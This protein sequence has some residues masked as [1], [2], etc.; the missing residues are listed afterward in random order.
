MGK[1]NIDPTAFA[2]KSNLAEEPVH[3]VDEPEVLELNPV[4]EKEHEN[5]DFDN[6]LASLFPGKERK[7]IQKINKSFYLEQHLVQRLEEI[8]KANDCSSSSVLNDILK[9]IL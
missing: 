9:Q 8:G 6:F 5:K 4:Q 7:K 2:Y 3:E 1:M